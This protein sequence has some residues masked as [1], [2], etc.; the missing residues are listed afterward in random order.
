MRQQG[1]YKWRSI[2]MILSF[3]M[4]MGWTTSEGWSAE[5]K[6][7]TR[8]IQVVI[9]FAPGATD[10]AIRPFTDKLQEVVGQPIN[11]EYKPGAGGA[12]GASFAAKAKPDGYTLLGCSS[13]PIITSP[14]TKEG[15]DYKLDD[16]VPICRICTQPSI[17]VVKADARWKTLKEL[18]EEAKKSPGKLTYSTAGVF[19]TDH[20]AM[21]VLH[22]LGGFNTTHVPST[23]VGPAVTATLGGHV[24]YACGPTQT[25]SPHI[26]S[27]ALRGI[28]VTGEERLQEFPDI[29]SASELGYPVFY[30]GWYGL[31]GPKGIPGEVLKII[32]NA[33]DKTMEIH[34]KSVED[35]LRKLLIKPAYIKGEEFG[36]FLNAL[37][38]TTK[39]VVEDLKQ[40][41]K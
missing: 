19:G 36:K 8:P 26:K 12:I 14:L 33:C 34:K 13:S 29:P 27:G 24:D 21:E 16:F 6:F 28:A 39:K 20:T 31:V 17:I 18:I 2:L 37:N 41:K 22:K 35:H 32:Y 3:I 15:L 11:F 10:I 5:V 30:V 7:P 9:G 1:Y 38:D 25:V 40:P 23:G 4:V